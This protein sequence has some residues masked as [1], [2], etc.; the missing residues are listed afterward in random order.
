MSASERAVQTS[1]SPAASLAADLVDRVEELLLAVEKSGQPLEIDPQRS[2]LFELFVMADAGGFLAEDAA[3]DLS[4]DGIGRE[5]ASRWDLSRNIVPGAT[6][7]SGLPAGQLSKLR[8]LWAF[9]RMWMEW[10][11]AWQR[12]DEFHGP[13]ERR[14]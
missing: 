9:M 11:Y 1:R 13:G 3:R 5:L 8:L 7:L 14:A 12:W 6:N 4:C 10:T 2:R